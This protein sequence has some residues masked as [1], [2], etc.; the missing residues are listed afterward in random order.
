MT[1]PYVR[2]RFQASGEREQS[3]ASIS[4]HDLRLVRVGLA[5]TFSAGTW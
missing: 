3:S 2:H 5:M 4:P 1:R